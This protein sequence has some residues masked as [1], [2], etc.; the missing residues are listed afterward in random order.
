MDDINICVEYSK[1][2]TTSDVCTACGATIQGKGCLKLGCY[3]EENKEEKQWYH[4]KCFWK[5]C[6]YPDVLKQEDPNSPSFEGYV[7]LKSG[8]KQKIISALKKF[9]NEHLSNVARTAHALKSSIPN[10]RKA[11]SSTSTCR[12]ENKKTADYTNR[13]KGPCGKHMF[14]IHEDSMKYIQIKHK[15]RGVFV[16]LNE[17]YLDDSDNTWMPTSPGVRLSIKEWEDLYKGRHIIDDA[18][19]TANKDED[20]PRSKKRKAM[21]DLPTSGDLVDIPLYLS[22]TRPVCVKTSF[23]NDVRQVEVAIGFHE[24]ITY[25][26]GKPSAPYYLPVT[27][28]TDEWANLMQIRSEVNEDLVDNFDTYCVDI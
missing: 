28:T 17:F 23:E 13:S 21:T 16:I 27:L 2:G 12:L 10:K 3:T 9:Q 24:H 7:D 11:A 22:E 19:K 1:P 4:F 25:V 18:I 15:K 20:E 8:D 6:K 14:R 26:D 5:E